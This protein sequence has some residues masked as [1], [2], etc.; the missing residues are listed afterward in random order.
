MFKIFK[1]I[2]GINLISY[3]LIFFIM[4][5]N[6]FVVGYNFYF[7]LLQIVTHFETLLFIPGLY[8]I[9]SSL[10]KKNKMI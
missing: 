10:Q 5:L 6:L 8:L 3:S 9:G 1:I 4:Y 7:Y 2:I